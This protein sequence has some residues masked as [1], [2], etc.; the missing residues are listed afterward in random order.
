MIKSLEIKVSGH[1][2]GVN[3]RY[4]AAQIAKNLSLVGYVKNVAGGT[5][6]IYAEGTK[7]SLA[8]LLDWAKRGPDFAKVE[9]I[10]V[11]W[12]NALNRYTNFEIIY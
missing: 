12:G 1:V 7:Q 5:V 4:D 9:K 2:Q 6:L 3:F 11:R 8:Q 10:D